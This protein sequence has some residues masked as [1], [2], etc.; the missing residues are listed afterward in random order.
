[1][2]GHKLI[3]LIRS[4]NTRASDPGRAA[5]VTLRAARHAFGRPIAD[6]RLH[7]HVLVEKDS[8]QFDFVRLT[9]AAWGAVLLLILSSLSSCTCHAL[10]NGARAIPETLNALFRFNS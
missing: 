4:V 9:L 8:F 2:S 7:A 3:E 6:R 1:M 10:C 5:V